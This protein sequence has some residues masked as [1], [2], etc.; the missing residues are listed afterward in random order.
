LSG[1]VKAGLGRHIHDEQPMTISEHH[2][3][4]ALAPSRSLKQAAIKL[5]DGA[6]LAFVVIATSAAMA[7]WLYALGW[8]AFTFA[9]WVIG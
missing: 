2:D 3:A 9:M 5:R 6:A 1:Q 7:G 8:V 4:A